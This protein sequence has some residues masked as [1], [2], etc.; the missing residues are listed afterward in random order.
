VRAGFFRSGK[1]IHFIAKQYDNR[2]FY[3]HPGEWNI[4]R[5]DMET[6]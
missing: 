6:W 1:K 3:A 4:W 2:D 5:A